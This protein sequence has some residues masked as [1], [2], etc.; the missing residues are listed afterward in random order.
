MSIPHRH[1]DGLVSHQFLHGTDVHSRHDKSAG[2]GVPE[3][4]PVEI[5]DARPLD[6][7]LKPAPPILLPP[8]IRSVIRDH[9]L[10]LSRRNSLTKKNVL[11]EWEGMEGPVAGVSVRPRSKSETKTGFAVTSVATR[12]RKIGKASPLPG[13]SLS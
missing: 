3:I 1:L 4:V 8:A 5:L 12:N 9:G 6:R 7:R 2:E 11:A 10:P 13:A